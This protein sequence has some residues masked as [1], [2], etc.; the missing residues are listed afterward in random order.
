MKI[1][2]HR[3]RVE[4]PHISSMA[5]LVL[6]STGYRMHEVRR[7]LA[8]RDEFLKDFKKKHGSLFC[9]YCGKSDLLAELPVWVRK[10]AML[11][12]I[13]HVIPLS[14]GGQRFERSN[15]KLACFS[16]NQ[17]KADKMPEA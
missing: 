8:F 11:A 13:D 4:F 12:T 10:S 6:L 15:L 14:K 17:E 16:C 3:V 2:H 7:W 5:S 9:E 1:R